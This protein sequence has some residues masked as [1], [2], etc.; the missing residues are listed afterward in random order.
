[1]K[2]K[3]RLFTSFETA[4]F[5]L[6]DVVSSSIEFNSFTA[7]KSR[8]IFLQHGDC[9]NSLPHRERCDIFK[10]FDIR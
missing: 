9:Y 8:A 6:Y 3:R 7:A 4:E 5:V 1:M 10:P 2:I